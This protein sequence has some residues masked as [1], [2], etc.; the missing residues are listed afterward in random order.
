MTGLNTRVT[1]V[2]DRLTSLENK[3]DAGFDEMR[4]AIDRLGARWGISG[5]TDRRPGWSRSA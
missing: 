4:R 5:C 3:M 1:S 2:E